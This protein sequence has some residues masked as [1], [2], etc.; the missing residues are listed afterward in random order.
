M[1]PL[2]NKGWENYEAMQ[3]IIF[4][5]A[6]RG[7]HIY[8][9]ALASPVVPTINDADDMRLKTLITPHSVAAAATHTSKATHTAATASATAGIVESAAPMDVDH[10]VH[11]QVLPPPPSV[12]FSKRSHSVMSLESDESAIAAPSAVHNIVPKKQQKGLARSGVSQDSQLE[13]TRSRNS[14][15]NPR[16]QS[17]P[18]HE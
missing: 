14:Q 6:A 18:V 15:G 10:P 5:T 7:S 2:K 13:G 3:V 1:K 16:A 11:P 8:R 17:S 4:S 12:N 9:P